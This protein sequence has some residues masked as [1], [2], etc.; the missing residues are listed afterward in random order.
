MFNTVL[1]WQDFD[2]LFLCTKFCLNCA[3]LFP[4]NDQLCLLKILWKQFILLFFFYLNLSYVHDFAEDF[5]AEKS[6]LF[7]PLQAILKK[8]F[9]MFETII[10]S[11][12]PHGKQFIIHFHFSLIPSG[13]L[14]LIFFRLLNYSI[15]IILK[16]NCKHGMHGLP[17]VLHRIVFVTN[18]ANSLM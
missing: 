6:I 13:V 5:S 15:W 9:A 7:I 3:L 14:F 11:Y 2:H 1:S 10:Y 17:S 8:I 4:K 12:Y 16:Q 18:I